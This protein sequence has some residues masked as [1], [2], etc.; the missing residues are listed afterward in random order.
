MRNLKVIIEYDGTNYFGFQAQKNPYLPTIQD[1]LEELLSKLAKE[2]IQ[3]TVAGRTD[4]GVHASGQ[5]INFR[6][7]WTI[8]VDRVVLAMNSGGL[9]RDIVAREAEEVP[10]DFHA[11]FDAKEK[12]YCYNIYNS[13]I[14]SAFHQRYSHFVPQ[15]LDINK[16]AV[17]SKYLLGTHDFS[18]FKATGST[19]K[20]NIRTIYEA[21]VKADGPLITITL[22]GNGFLYNMVRIIAGTLIE[23]GRGK[24]QPDDLAEIIASR[25]RTLAGITAPA[26]GLCLERVIY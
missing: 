26:Q 18:A 12:I 3:V 10:L 25:D 11:R 14:P 7:N 23:V 19:V 15:R 22:R 4:A 9:P 2:P 5:V 16:M 13:R 20:N 24:L 21:G 6:T 8:P 17:S 1:T